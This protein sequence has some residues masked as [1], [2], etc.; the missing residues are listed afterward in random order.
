MLSRRK[1]LKSPMEIEVD[2][3]PRMGAKR[4]LYQNGHER[5]RE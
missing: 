4:R 2:S 3:I 5:G 1:E